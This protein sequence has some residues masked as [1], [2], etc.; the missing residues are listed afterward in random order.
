MAVHV[1]ASKRILLKATNP[2][3]ILQMTTSALI[4]SVC[5]GH[6]GGVRRYPT[7]C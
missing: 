1:P 2:N 4:N 7:Q 5:I 3:S 6:S